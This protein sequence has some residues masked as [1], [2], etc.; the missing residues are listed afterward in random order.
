[1]ARVLNPNPKLRAPVADPFGHG[2][3]SDSH[4]KPA[5]EGKGHT[6]LDRKKLH[7][8]DGYRLSL[9]VLGGEA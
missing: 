5:G 1:M 2:H 6:Y 3:G 4:A 7:T 8:D 9:A